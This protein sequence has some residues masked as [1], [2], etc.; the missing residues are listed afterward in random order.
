MRR[1]KRSRISS[2]IVMD[3]MRQA[4]AAEA[5]GHEIVHMEVG[6]P[7]TSAPKTALQA[8]KAALDHDALGYTLA[9]GRPSLRARI[10]R[11]Y[12]DAYGVEVDPG[13]VIITSGSSA[14]FVLAFLS[15]FD[16]GDSIALP[17]PGYPCYRH[18]LSALGHHTPL[19][20]TG[21]ETR[22]MPTVD[23]LTRSHARAGLS[24]LV[25]ASPANPTG[26][27]M[28]AEVLGQIASFCEDHDIWLVSDEIYHGLTYEHPAETALKFSDRAII[29]NSFS[30]YYSMTGWRIGWLVVPEYLVPVVERLAQNFYISPPTL[31]QIAAEAAFDGRDELEQ[32]R[33]VYAINRDLLCDALRAIGLTQFAPADGAF[34]VYVDVSELTDDAAVLARHLL[35][36]CGIAATPGTDFDT[37]HGHRFLRFCYAGTT[38]T[39]ETAIA[40]LKAWPRLRSPE[41]G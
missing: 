9:L 29:V 28:S 21:P 36:D 17:S 12:Q 37:E 22:W 5:A 34:Y 23:A 27:M 7:G 41:R 30:K 13:R 18:I 40:R 8:A 32:N 11:H 26:T 24:G 3:V 16:S 20:E 38:E 6:Q 10:A 19:I 33:A 14:G 15:L 31:A 1:S 35:E 4:A 25:L 39:I 2:F